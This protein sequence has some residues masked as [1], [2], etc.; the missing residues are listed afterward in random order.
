MP[1]RRRPASP[2]FSAAESGGGGVHIRP[3][4]VPF[5]TVEGGY[6]VNVPPDHKS[7]AAHLMASNAPR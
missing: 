2:S 7:P 6:V 1:V 4:S 5:S 3:A